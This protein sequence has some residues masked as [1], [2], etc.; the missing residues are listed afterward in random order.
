MMFSSR[1]EECR[2][3]PDALHQD[4]ISGTMV[5]RNVCKVCLCIEEAK[6]PRAV[7]HYHALGVRPVGV[8]EGVGGPLQDGKGSAFF[9]GPCDL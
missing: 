4:E 2:S 3:G 8:Q 7:D 1:S 9:Q 6:F 5:L